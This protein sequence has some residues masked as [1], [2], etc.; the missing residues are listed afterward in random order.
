V[1][2]ALEAHRAARLGC[3]V[4]EQD[5]DAAAQAA[6]ATAPRHFS[7]AAADAFGATHPAVPTA[8]FACPSCGRTVQ[9]GRFAPHLEKCL[10]KGRTAARAATKRAAGGAAAAADGA[11]GGAAGA[12]DAFAPA[13]SSKRNHKKKRPAGAGAAAAAV[14]ALPAHAPTHATHAALLSS[15]AAL[16][17]WRTPALPLLRVPQHGA[18]CATR[19]APQ[20]SGGGATPV[21]ASGAS[22]ASAS[23]SVDAFTPLPWSARGTRPLPARTADVSSWQPGAKPPPARAPLASSRLRPPW[24]ACPVGVALPPGVVAP[25]LPPPVPA[26]P[27]PPPPLMA[28]PLGASAHALPSFYPTQQHYLPPTQPQHQH[29]P[30]PPAAPRN[31]GGAAALAPGGKSLDGRRRKELRTMLASAVSLSDLHDYARVPPVEPLSLA[32][33]AIRAAAVG[34]RDVDAG[35]AASGMGVTVIGTAFEAACVHEGER[36]VAAVMANMCSVVSQRNGTLGRLCSNGLGCSN[37]R[38][39]ARAAM[40]AQL[41]PRCAPHWVAPPKDETR[42]EARAAARAAAHPKQPKH[43]QHAQHHAQHHAPLPPP[44][45]LGAFPLAS[46]FAMHSAAPPMMMMP[47]M[48]PHMQPHGGG[49]VTLLGLHMGMDMHQPMAQPRQQACAPLLGGGGLLGLGGGGGDSDGDDTLLL[50]PGAGGGAL[51]GSHDDALFMLC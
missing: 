31:R 39:P 25:G 8:E 6:A 50:P 17:P 13:L 5:D 4:E 21:T 1:D 26:P 7:R 38:E 12:A 11:P 44:L 46:E 34:F 51:M 20:P 27:R 47:H 40:R 41:L 49:G 42:E 28:P 35:A 9:A 23:A 22:A 48:Q 37:H 16:A 30:P 2:V 29:Y 24:L 33:R 45:P 43:T 18:A 3:E 32:A 15:A 36:D 19:L 14:P 10:G